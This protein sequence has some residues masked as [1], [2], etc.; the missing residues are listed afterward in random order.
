MSIHCPSA[1]SLIWFLVHSLHTFPSPLLFRH[2][3]HL[4]VERFF[5][6]SRLCTAGMCSCLVQFSSWV[7]TFVRCGFLFIYM[8]AIIWFFLFFSSQSPLDS[9]ASCPSGSSLPFPPSSASTVLSI[10]LRRCV[11]FSP[12]FPSLSLLS[13]LRWILLVSSVLLDSLYA[14]INPYC[15]SFFAGALESRRCSW[16]SQSAILYRYSC[17]FTAHSS[18][19]YYPA[20]ATISQLLSLYLFCYVLIALSFELFPLFGTHL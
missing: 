20:R 17:A 15:I 12:L 3:Y 10:L 8:A 7:I 19:Y 13:C 9:S 16:V 4:V 11:R 1:P 5:D 6:A 14:T 2:L 18:T